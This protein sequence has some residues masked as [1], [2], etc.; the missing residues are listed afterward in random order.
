VDKLISQYPAV[1]WP[2]MAAALVTAL[3]VIWKQVVRPIVAWCRKVLNFLDDV[4]GESARP[5][6]DARPGLMERARSIE[7]TQVDHGDRLKKIEYQLEP[8]SG[9]SLRDAVDRVEQAVTTE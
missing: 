5:G 6:V 8:N 2:L 1:A 4:M 7:V 9:S 3:G